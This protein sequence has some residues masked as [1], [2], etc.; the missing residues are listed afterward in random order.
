MVA[1]NSNSLQIMCLYKCKKIICNFHNDSHQ[2][3]ND[4]QLLMDTTYCPFNTDD[5]LR[6]KLTSAFKDRQQEVWPVLVALQYNGDHYMYYI[7][8][9]LAYFMAFSLI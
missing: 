9:I 1:G 4:R 8:I 2:Y 5:T 3:S 6:T 7:Y